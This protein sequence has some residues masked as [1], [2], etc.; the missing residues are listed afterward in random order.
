MDIETIAHRSDDLVRALIDVWEASVRATHLFLAE[1]DIVSLKP[2]VG[3]GIAGTE[4]LAVAFDHGEPCGFAGAQDGHL[5]MLFVAPG[6]RGRGVG[7]ALLA[8]AVKEYSVRTLD[9][10]EQNPLA[11]GFY[12]HEGFAVVGRSPRDDAGR[13]FPLLHMN[14]SGE[15][16][17]ACASEKA[18]EGGNKAASSQ[19]SAA[20]CP[21]RIA[22]SPESAATLPANA[23]AR[24]ALAS[25]TW[26]DAADTSLMRDHIHACE[27]MARFNA[28]QGML[29]ADRMELLRGLFG[30][31]GEDS[32]VTGGAQVD[33]G[34][35][36][37]MGER[38]FFNFNCTFLD[39]VPITFGDDVWAGPGCT[40][41]TPLHP[42]VGRE[43]AASRDAEGV[44]HLWER[45]LPITVGNDVWLAANVTVNPGVT[46]GDGAVIGSGSVV[47]KDIPARMLAYGNPCRVVREI[48]D[49]DSVAADLAE[50]GLI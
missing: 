49:V 12:E 38:C 30:A 29:D 11:V 33:Y 43:R 18:A 39:G 32:A 44:S 10:N 8:H 6:A 14:L 45:N 1:E 34:Y 9:V 4:Q 50:A 24:A 16:E 42:L 40:F 2:E 13:P 25:G 3:P 26:A 31:I 23:K 36:I 35:N 20:E 5:D 17:T 48:T 37:F 41:V 22:G 21:G 7:R 47:T 46:I 15:G 27:V 28:Q 19:E